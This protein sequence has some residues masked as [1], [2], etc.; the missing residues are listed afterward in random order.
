MSEKMKILNM[1]ENGEISLDEG[2][3]RIKELDEL[4]LSDS[5]PV[6]ETLDILSKIESGEISATDGIDQ[7]TSKASPAS[8]STDED[9]SLPH[10][11]PPA[12]FVND[13][14]L[15]RWKN[16]WRNL[17]YA[18]VAIAILGTLWMSSAYQNNGY[19]FW[20]FCS[21][22]PLSIGILVTVLA[23]KSQSGPWIHIRV[24][25]KTDN[26]AISLPAPL[27]LTRWGLRTFGRFIPYLEHTSV[28]EIIYALENTSK[29]NS[30]F[31]V[32]VDEEEEGEKVE[33]FIG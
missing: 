26:V 28:D 4:E 12:E 24:R 2:I 23:L 32:H 33:I 10:Q 19:G 3:Q 8:K 1:I 13:K 6:Y 5:A 11:A 29:N 22:I 15:A 7:I 30:P 9:V 27:G 20:F 25:S 17:L 18:G 14:E 21:W 31:Y 16:W